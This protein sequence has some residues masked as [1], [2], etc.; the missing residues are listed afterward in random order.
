MTWDQLRHFH[1]EPR[2]IAAWLR[3][4]GPLLR[5]LT[6]R[7]RRILLSCGALVV[8]VKYPLKNLTRT[9]EQSGGTAD[10]VSVGLV[11][12]VLFCFVFLCYQAARRFAGLPIFVRLHPQIS[13]HA[14]FWLLL[15]ALWF[16]QPQ[17]LVRTSIVG[18]IIAL[19]FLLWRI[20]YM[21]FTAQRG[22][23]AATGFTDHLFYIYPVWG[24]SDTPYGKGS[25]YLSANE[26][27][28]ENA[29]AR[30]QLAGLKC[31]FLAGLWTIAKGL[32][33]GCVFA[34]A[35]FFHRTLGSLSPAVPR[36][37]AMFADP[38]SSP[39]WLCWIA[40]YL[41]LLW[42]VFALAASGHVVVG[43]LRL[44]GFNVFRNTYKPLLA[45]SVVEFWNRYYY[46]FKELLVNFFFY[47]TFTRHFKTSPKLRVFAAVFAAA[48]VGNMYYHWLR[49]DEALVTTD[50]H[51]MWAALQSRLFY[52]F[53][54]ALGIYISMRRAQRKTSSVR[55]N[56]R[57]AAAIFGVWTFFS[58]IHI[59]AEKDPALFPERMKFFLGLFGV[60]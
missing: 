49:L 51:A 24:G 39:I 8:A 23:M 17:G 36:L 4:F 1:K 59:W 48:F 34:E 15:I 32:L 56:T 50:F 47:P 22:K 13:L 45:E 21:M 52:C 12:V 30:S 58:I 41:E 27:R 35:N 46:Y 9:A 42:A 19:P 11:V 10:G 31:F 26:A 18:C 5:A 20:G 54:L 43:W 6:P 25:D 16:A 55:S 29:L 38:L 7:R 28:D 33:A 60:G 3:V 14:I 53:M 44:F 40:L 57:R 2:A 37:G